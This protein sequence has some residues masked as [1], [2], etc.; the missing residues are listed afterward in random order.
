MSSPDWLLVFWKWFS[1]LIRF[2]GTNESVF[3]GK[4]DT[5]SQWHD[6]AIG[7]HKMSPLNT[8][9]QILIQIKLLDDHIFDALEHFYQTKEY[10]GIG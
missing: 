5:S 3:N 6:M 4:E 7:V 1:N 8:F 9:N 10:N 2:K